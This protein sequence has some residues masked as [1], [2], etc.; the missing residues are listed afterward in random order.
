MTTDK[1]KW[2]Q[3]WMVYALIGLLLILPAYVGGYYLLGDCR[4]Y[5]IQ[6]DIFGQ[7][8]L[9]ICHFRHFNSGVLRIAFGPLGWAEAKLRGERVRLSSPGASNDYETGG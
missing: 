6:A 3:D 2:W 1:P 9:E 7:S 4:S 8:D 5:L